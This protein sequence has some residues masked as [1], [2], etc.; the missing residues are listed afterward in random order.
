MTAILPEQAVDLHLHTIASDG[1]WTV[2]ALVEH[3]VERSFRVAA[4]CDHDTMAS[5][6]RA[7]EVGERYGLHV[8][9]GVEVTTRWQGRQWHLLVYG[10]DP[11][12]PAART[13]RAV[14]DELADR[15]WAAAVDAIVVLERHGY[16]LRSLREV[17]AGRPLRPYHVL[18]TLIREGYATNL[19]T[20]HDLTKRLGEPMLVDVPLERVVAAARAAGGVCILA[21]PGRDDGAGVLEAATLE[22][23]VTAVP[24]D[25]LEVHYRSHS[26]EQTATF[27]AWCEQFGLVASAGSDSHA[28]GIPVDPIP[29]RAE[30]IAPLLERLGIEILWPAARSRDPG[31]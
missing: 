18:T 26:P 29:Y 4:I 12:S 27:R 1:H 9:P 7:V 3:L 2:E 30:W 28:P 8:V 23:M 17:A 25:G 10:I 22:R 11:A 24:V 20:A 6:A 5:V 31:A 19:A 13:F 16:R 21:H 15:L 14:L